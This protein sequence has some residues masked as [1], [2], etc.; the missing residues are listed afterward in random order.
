MYVLQWL[1]LNQYN[2]VKS[3]YFQCELISFSSPMWLR[4]DLLIH[5]ISSNFYIHM[6]CPLFFSFFFVSLIVHNQNVIMILLSCYFVVVVVELNTKW[7]RKNLSLVISLQIIEIEVLFIFILFSQRK[8]SLLNLL[9]WIIKITRPC[10]YVKKFKKK[11]NVFILLNN[12]SNIIIFL[13]TLK[14]EQKQ[15]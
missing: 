10:V 14:V 3:S 2:V 7:Y 1:L 12:L 9:W 11:K 5:F 13:S 8:M 6:Q 15:Y 4:I